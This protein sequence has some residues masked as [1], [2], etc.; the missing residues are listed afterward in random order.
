M[1]LELCEDNAG[2]LSSV[3]VLYLNIDK[4]KYKEEELISILSKYIKNIIVTDN[5]QDAKAKAEGRDIDILITDFNLADEESMNFPL[6]I[7]RCNPSCSII[8]YTSKNDPEHLLEAINMKVDKYIIKS[9]SFKEIIK[10]IINLAEHAFTLKALYSIVPDKSTHLDTEAYDTIS[11][12]IDE[13]RAIISK[14]A[15]QH[16]MESMPIIH[17]LKGIIERMKTLLKNSY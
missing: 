10:A 14:M 4:D 17:S 8:I 5:L 15:S 3:T 9:S 2:L 16:C 7:R 1:V 12:S 6:H 11:Q 13:L